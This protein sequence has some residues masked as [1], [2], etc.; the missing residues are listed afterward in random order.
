MVGCA[1]GGDERWMRM[2]DHGKTL[3]SSLYF[4]VPTS[5]QAL[6]HRGAVE[7]QTAVSANQPCSSRSRR[8]ATSKDIMA[9]STR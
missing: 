3:S 4:S 9:P 5:I 6:Q 2:T 1:D 7:P 8:K